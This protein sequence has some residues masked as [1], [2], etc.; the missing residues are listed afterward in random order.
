[1]RVVQVM[2]GTSGDGNVPWWAELLE[3]PAWHREAACRG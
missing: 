3:R 1:M 2:T